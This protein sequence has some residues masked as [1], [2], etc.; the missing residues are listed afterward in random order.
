M[1]SI[2]IV[3]DEER[4]VSFLTHG[5]EADGHTITAVGDGVTAAGVARDDDFDLMIL[6]VGLPRKDGLSVLQEIRARGERMPVVILTARD[7]TADTVA[8]LDA[9]ADDYVTKPFKFAE[10]LARVHA[11]LRDQGTMESAT[12]EVGSATLDLWKRVAVIDGNTIELSAREFTLASMLFR[13][14]DQVLSREQILSA[15]WGYD[16][17]PDSNVVE[18]YVGYLRKK[19]GAHRIENVR[20]MGYR[21]RI[22]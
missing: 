9:G 4:I 3:E 17:E 13:H 10:L 16:F 7:A 22:E 14:P 12:I 15:V 6:D 18:V 20:R 19:L 11:R 21:L 1:A 2:L 5:L 8:G